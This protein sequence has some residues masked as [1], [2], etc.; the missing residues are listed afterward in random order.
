MSAG[1]G[2]VC[3][4][5]VVDQF[6]RKNGGC[7]ETIGDSSQTAGGRETKCQRIATTVANYMNAGGKGTHS[8]Y[9]TAPQI[10]A[11][12][13]LLIASAGEEDTLSSATDE[14]ISQIE[15]IVS[16]TDYFNMEEQRYRAVCRCSLSNKDSTGGEKCK[17]CMPNEPCK[18]IEAEVSLLAKLGAG[19]TPKD[20]IGWNVEPGI[21]FETD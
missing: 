13:E 9:V 20:T 2:D 14:A 15:L 1:C 8:G 11:L 5:P 17:N 21:C 7:K 16:A 6:V 19:G 18:T 12:V 3:T 10:T 4:A